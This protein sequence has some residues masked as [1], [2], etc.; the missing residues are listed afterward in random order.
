MILLDWFFVDTQSQ[1]KYNPH[2]PLGWTAL[3]EEL[4]KVDNLRRTPTE[5][6]AT[7]IESVESRTASGIIPLSQRFVVSALKR[8]R[9]TRKSRLYSASAGFSAATTTAFR[10]AMNDPGGD[11]SNGQQ[12]RGG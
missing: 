3:D 5:D 1:F 9:S 11:E 2:N 6:P 4:Y 10:L 7:L 8:M 12:K